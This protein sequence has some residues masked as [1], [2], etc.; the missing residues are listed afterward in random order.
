M[1]FE[2]MNIDQM[3]ALAKQIDADAQALYNLVNNLNGILAGLVFTWNGPTAA[4][5]EQEWQHKN[6]PALLSA[7]TILTNLHKHLVDNINQQTSASAADSY[8]ADGLGGA[9]LGIA[10]A[11]WG[12]VETVEPLAAIPE[13]LISKEEDLFNHAPPDPAVKGPWTW[14]E[15]HTEDPVFP[16]IK[17]T[18]P[19]RWLHDTPAL[20]YAD[21]LLV[22]THVYKVLDKVIEPVNLGIAVASVGVD[23]GQASLDAAHGDAYGA[24]NHVADAEADGL[25]AIP[26]VGQLAGFDIEVAK[27]DIN[28][29]V[30]GGPIPSPFSW[31]NLKEDYAPL[32]GEMWQQLLLDKGQLLNMALGGHS[33]DG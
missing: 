7:Y 9:A 8:G 16:E 29:V 27:A 33:S 20:R 19:L 31:K 30:T 11:I 6:R 32:P 13:Y 14:L 15:K 12:V 10:A 23:L 26:I 1:S 28:E 4:A 21:D 3:Q 24:A 5:F 17:D 18:R 2:G 22:K 25:G